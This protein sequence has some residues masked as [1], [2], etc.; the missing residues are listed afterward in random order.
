MHRYY[1]YSRIVSS[2]G[3]AYRGSSQA[4]RWLALPKT[5]GMDSRSSDD[6]SKAGKAGNRHVCH[7]NCCSRHQA[8]VTIL[9]D[10][11]CMNDWACQP[12]S[13]ADA[14]F[15]GVSATRHVRRCYLNA[16]LQVQLL[17]PGIEVVCRVQLARVGFLLLACA[18]DACTCKAAA[19]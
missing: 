17:A 7:K 19:K 6:A 3:H 10:R 18:R 4:Q 12:G 16:S 1:K 13:L 15:T 5:S 14:N 11:G 8:T 9:L 2:R